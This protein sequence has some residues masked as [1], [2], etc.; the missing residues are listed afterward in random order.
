MRPPVP[1]GAPADRPATRAELARLSAWYQ[2]SIDWN[3]P[4]DPS[5]WSDRKRQLFKEQAHTALETLR[6][7]LGQGWKVRDESLL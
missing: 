1:A 4:P 7:E 5:P 2:S 3:D 6:S